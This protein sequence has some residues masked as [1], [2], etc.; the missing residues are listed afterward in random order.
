MKNMKKIIIALF[1]TVII[2]VGCKKSYLDI[3]QNPNQ[4]TAVTP[5]VVLSSSLVGTAANIGTDYLGLTR[6][7][8]YFSRSGNY[9]PDVQTETYNIT[10]DYTDGEW[11]ALYLNLNN[12]NYIE[13]IGK[14][15]SLPFYIGVAKA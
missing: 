10:N 11:N 4:P 3:N 14:Q 9:V 12:Y 13:N 5:N 15:D 7:M 2:G 1:A 8:G 6:W